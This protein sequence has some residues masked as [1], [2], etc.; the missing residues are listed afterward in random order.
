MKEAMNTKKTYEKPLTK[1]FSI[2][3]M[4]LLLSDS[5]KDTIGDGDEVTPTTEETDIVRS[6]HQAVWDDVDEEEL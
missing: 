2:Q 3:A 5:L 1:S 6:R 4:S